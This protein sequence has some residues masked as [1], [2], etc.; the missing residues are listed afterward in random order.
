MFKKIIFLLTIIISIACSESKMDNNKSDCD[1]IDIVCTE[2]FRTITLEIVDIHNTPVILDNFKIT[3]EDTGEEIE[4][5]KNSFQNFYP[6]I[7]DSYQNEIAHKEMN[8]NFT[9]YIN[10]TEVVSTVYVVSADCCHI[11][12]VS[13][14]TKIILQ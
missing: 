12:L 6:I 8:L 7:N 13:G 11:Y 3:R 2:E 10:N 14:E 5:N 4:L 1:L 9:G